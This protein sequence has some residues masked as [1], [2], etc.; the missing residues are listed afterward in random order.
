[1]KIAISGAGIAGPTL[2]YWLGRTGHHATLIEK[3]RALR[4]GGYV[5]DF[6]GAGY[7]IAERM[8]LGPQLQ[9]AGYAVREVRLVDR[10]GDKVGGFPTDGFRRMAAGRFTSLARGDLAA[11]IYGT[12][13]DDVESL[14]AQSI[15]TIEQDDTGVRV[16]FHSGASREFD[17][18]IGTGGLHSPV[19]SLVF[20]PE[21]GFERD[22]GYRVAAFEARGYRPRDELIYVSY[23]IPGGMV[24]RFAMRDDR[25]MFLFVFTREQIG[26]ADPR[27]TD[28]VKRLLGAVFGGTGWECPRI[29]QAMDDCEDIYFDRVSQIAMNGWSDGRVMLIGDAAAAVSLLAGEGTG[30]AMLQAYVLAG[31]LHRA[32]GDYKTAFHEYQR[33]LRPF[34]TGKQRSAQRFAATFAPRTRRGLWA[35]DKLTSLL[36]LPFVGDWIIHRQ[37]RDD[38]DL[39]DYGI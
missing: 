19:R 12:L 18:L 36:S 32:G 27:G 37:L 20:G 1:M 2:A 24:S 31:E 39:P 10:R 9:T 29:L 22:L 23:G 15:A 3:A 14:F 8:G 30:L 35:R 28:E 21:A 34:I 38:F 17:L 26:G 5:V 4:T 11:M 16:G 6:W 7:R 13:A 25:T 33:L